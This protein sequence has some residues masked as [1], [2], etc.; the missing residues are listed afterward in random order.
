VLAAAAGLLCCA[1]WAGTKALIVPAGLCAYMAALDIIEPLAQQLDHPDREESTPRAAG[2]VR[3]LL[4]V[5]PMVALTVLGL[6]GILAAVA[7]GAPVATAFSVG[8]P[9]AIATGVLACAGAA[10]STIKGPDLPS[11]GAMLTPEIAGTQAIFRIGFPPLCGV[12]GMVPVLTGH[13]AANRGLPPGG[14][15]FQVVLPLVGVI[16]G[17]TLAWVRFRVEIQAFLAEAGKAGAGGAK[18]PVADR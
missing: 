1:A 15:A 12:L 10:V 11:G 9:V 8:V 18:P 2:A 4:L 6:V 14:P 5:V 3:V 16:G 13:A 17:L 7:A